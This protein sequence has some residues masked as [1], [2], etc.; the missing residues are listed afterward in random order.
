MKIDPTH[1]MLLRKEFERDQDYEAYTDRAY[2]AKTGGD[3]IWV[4]ENP[5]IYGLDEEENDLNQAEIE[6]N[7]DDYVEVPTLSHTDHHNILKDFLASDWT[8]NKQ[9]KQVVEGFYYGPNSIG[10]W[11]K[12]LFESIDS[13]YEIWEAYLGFKDQCIDLMFKDFLNKYGYEL[14]D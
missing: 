7:P 12:Q 9:L 3:V 11:K 10:L 13:A 1:E 6:E 8:D 2:L 14:G 5:S 4:Y